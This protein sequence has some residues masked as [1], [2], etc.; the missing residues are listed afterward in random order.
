MLSLGDSS[1]SLLRFS[2]V[3]VVAIFV[4]SVGATPSLLLSNIKLVIYIYIERKTYINTEYI[5][6][7]YIYTYICLYKR[8]DCAGGCSSRPLEDR[9]KRKK[10]GKNIYILEE[11]KLENTG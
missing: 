11:K 5:Q 4:I 10:K 9:K 3:V 8:K 6:F 2:V 1:S 7:I